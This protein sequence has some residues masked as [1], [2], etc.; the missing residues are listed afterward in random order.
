MRIIIKN[1]LF[2]FPKSLLWDLIGSNNFDQVAWWH[3]FKVL[4]LV[5]SFVQHVN[6]KLAIF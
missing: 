1:I 3:V 6:L 5:V 2:S 4:L